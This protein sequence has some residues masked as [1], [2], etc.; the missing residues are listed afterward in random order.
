MGH[1]KIELRPNPL[2]IFDWTKEFSSQSIN[3]DGTRVVLYEV[4]LHV[5]GV[6]VTKM[7]K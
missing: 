3:I 4:V 6:F 7:I 1:E 5:E 2:N